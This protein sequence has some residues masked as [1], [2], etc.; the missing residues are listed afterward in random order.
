MKYEAGQFYRADGS[1]L[2]SL[3]ELPID[4]RESDVVYDASETGA[5][6]WIWDVALDDAGRP[7]LAYTRLPAETEHIYHYARWNGSTWLDYP[8]SEAGGWF[9]QTPAG[10]TEREVHYSGGIVFNQTDPSIVYYSRPVNGQFELEKAVTTDGGMSWSRYPMTGASTQLNVRP[11]FPHGYTEASDH[12]LWMQGSYIHYT[13]YSTA[14][15]F[16]I[17]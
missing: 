8:I 17:P 16:T 12:V 1:A 13:D 14:I 11:V 6:A 4:H 15:R 3:N 5:R 7:V 10:E 9:P 2:G